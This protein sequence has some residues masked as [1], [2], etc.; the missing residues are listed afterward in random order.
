MLDD[1]C[2]G[3][4]CLSIVDHGIPLVIRLVDDLFFKIHGAKVKS[5]KTITEKLVN[6]TGIDNFVGQGFPISAVIKKIRIR[7]SLHPFKQSIDQFV[8]ASDGYTLKTVVEVV[9]VKDKSDR[10]S[11]DD[12][13][14]QFCTLA[15]PLLL[16]VA[17]DES[18]IDVIADEKFCLL[19]QIAG[20][21]HACSLH[22]LEGFLALAFNNG[23]CF[24][25]RGDSPHLMKGV[26]VE[27][28]VVEFALVVGNRR[29]G[30]AVEL[31]DMVDEI[32]NLTVAGVEDMGTVFV[33]IDTF[34]GLTVDIATK[35]GPLV[36]DKATLA[37]M[38]GLMGKCGTKES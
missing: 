15:S 19:F 4:R 9:V 13:S 26:H 10:K 23:L 37:M 31:N 8:V 16:R 7:S 21:C 24:L 25:R 12:E 2:V 5:S 22:A 18:L 36:N 20:F 28:Q 38:V 32:P 14:G 3:N 33:H 1:A 11:S 30:K 34:G 35:M 29:I 17:F 27:R 6:L